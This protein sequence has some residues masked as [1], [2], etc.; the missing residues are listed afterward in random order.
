MRELS[1][2]INIRKHLLSRT[3][4]YH[5]CNFYAIASCHSGK[6]IYQVSKTTYSEVFLDCQTGKDSFIAES[7]RIDDRE[8]TR[9]A[10]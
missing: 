8:Q 4:I 2:I 5:H 10:F 3:V 7:S 6:A 9:A 1:L